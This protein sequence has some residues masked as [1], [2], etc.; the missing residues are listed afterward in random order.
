[1]RDTI[2]TDRD[3]PPF[4]QAQIPYSELHSFHVITGEGKRKPGISFEHKPDTNEKGRDFRVWMKEELA[5][6]C[7]EKLMQMLQALARQNEFEQEF[8]VGDDT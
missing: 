3:P 4:C 6:D 8:K 2:S 7:A 5:T 1:M